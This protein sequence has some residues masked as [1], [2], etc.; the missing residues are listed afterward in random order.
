ME[1]NTNRE[2]EMTATQT[3]L[4]QAQ[5]ELRRISRQRKPLPPYSEVKA[6]RKRV[7]ELKAQVQEE[8]A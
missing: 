1:F 5:N 4:E 6:A 8:G 2:A 3:A 7:A